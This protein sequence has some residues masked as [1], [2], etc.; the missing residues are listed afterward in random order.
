MTRA[1]VPKR[2]GVVYLKDLTP[3]KEVQGGSGKRVFGESE[4]ENPGRDRPERTK[5]G[6]KRPTRT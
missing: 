5:K 1:R 4:A 3:Q 6:K 2:A